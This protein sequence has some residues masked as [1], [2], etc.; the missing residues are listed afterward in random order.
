MGVDQEQGLFSGYFRAG[1]ENLRAKLEE[2]RDLTEVEDTVRLYWDS[3]QH[4]FT[5]NVT[6][7]RARELGFELFVVAKSAISCMLSVSQAEVLFKAAPP[8]RVQERRFDWKQYVGAGA[9][10]LLSAY[11]LMEGMWAPMGVGLFATGW[12]VA[13]LRKVSVRRRDVPALPEAQGVPRADVDE[14]MRRLE[15]LAMSMDSAY[16]HMLGE[17]A[18]PAL[19]ESIEWSP[20]QLEAVQMLWEALRQD[21]GRYALKTLPQLI[22]ALEQQGMKLVEYSEDTA[23]YFERLPG[24][25][26]GYTIRPALMLGER[27]VARG[28]VTQ[29]MQ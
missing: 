14:L 17:S 19:P 29:K 5:S 8:E 22:M 26:D 18:K 13:M 27:L 6:D 15:R 16:G 2:C 11:L 1:R 25:E 24:V 23:K 21:D 10:L 4:E 3:M 20:E 7:G 12:Q 28:Q 9:T